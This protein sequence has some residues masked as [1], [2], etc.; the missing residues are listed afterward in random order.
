MTTYKIYYLTLLVL[1]MGL[2]Q[3][4]VRDGNQVVEN[5]TTIMIRVD[6]FSM[7]IEKIGFRYEFRDEHDSVI[8]PAHPISGLQMGKTGNDLLNA[9]NTKLIHKSEGSLELEVTCSDN[10]SAN[11]T[12][13]IVENG[14]KLS[15]TPKE[16]HLHEIVLRTGPVGPA[17][18]M[19][20]HAAFGEGAEDLELNNFIRDPFDP[21]NHGTH[22]MI[23]NFAIFPQQG[24]AEVNI[25][26]GEKLVR[27]TDQ[28]N[29][30]G[31]KRVRSLP[32]FYYFMGSPKQIY[33]SFLAS[34]NQEGYKVY[35][36]K[37]P[38]FGVGWE[39]FGALSWNTDHKTVTENIDRYLDYGY[40][41]RWMVVGSGFWPSGKGEFDRHGT[42]YNAEVKSQEDKKMQ[43]TT[44]FG[45]WDKKKYPDPKEFIAYFH[46]KGLI[47]TLGLRI[48][49]IPGG[50]FTDEGLQKKYFLTNANDQEV[51]YTPGFPRV[52][53]YLLDTQNDEAVT[54]YVA[55][56][57][58][59]M[60]YGVDGFKEDL[61]SHTG[62]LRDDLIDPVNR[63]LMEQDAY[64]MGRNN[65]LG[66]PA[67]LH[68]YNDF[69]Y[70]QPQDRGPINGLAYAFSGFANVYPD[71][72]GGTGLA[73]NRFGNKEK[74][75]LSK[76]LVRYT[77]YAALNPSMA[78]GYGP[79]NFGS[80][81]NQ[82]CLEAAELHG[83][84]HPY[85]YSNA[86]K[87]FRTGFPHPMIPLPLAFPKDKNVY[88]LA[89]TAQ[90]S[91]EWM[92]GDAL[93]AAPLFGDD[94][95][96]A[97]KRDIY[98]PKGT[99]MDYDSG[100]KFEGPL[101]L[102][103][104]DIPL[105]KI[106]LFVGGTGIVVENVAGKLKARIYPVRKIAETTYYGRDGETESI[107][108]IASPNWERPRVTDRTNGKEIAISKTRHAY[109]FDFEEGHDYLIH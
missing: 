103:N 40:P 4:C 79:W 106:P 36:P 102:E 82:L 28:E 90:R 61:F 59:W 19:A 54:W 38:W 21:K 51:L 30:Q 43:S 23:S 88:G 27:I 69:N 76:Y 35:K 49:F 56:C 48:G 53:V 10:S 58:K 87:A 13:T 86:I 101:L 94:V 44:S 18:G 85:I 95:G 20:D 60:A 29:A 31:S 71:I 66:S 25:E 72:I 45:M 83:R 80:E 1:I 47:F 42:P 62:S 17:Y 78:F 104:F 26:P 3:N 84:L 55:L 50:P 15:V 6:N 105:K 52:P 24:F 108:E 89:T 32:S 100:K 63:V 37:Y 65:Y 99:W 14:I 2:F 16:E 70:N 33:R 57:Q 64:I 12:L 107:L 97:T 98:L 91:Y 73:T 67:D 81:V 41:L 9:I 77:Q 75:K 34:R 46:Q 93:L 11:V 5:R 68:R 92:I 22:R 96:T 74:E 39:A 109:Q 8:V 7:D